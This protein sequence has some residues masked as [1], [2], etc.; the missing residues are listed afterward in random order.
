MPDV[1]RIGTSSEECH[2]PDDRIRDPRPRP[3]V[4]YDDDCGRADG[5]ERVAERVSDRR[6]VQW[7]HD[8]AAGYRECEKRSTPPA[9][10]T[11]DCRP[12]EL[13]GGQEKTAGQRVGPEVRAGLDRMA[14]DPVEC[15]MN[16]QAQTGRHDHGEA[17]DLVPR[18][19]TMPDKPGNG[20]AGHEVEMFLDGERPESREWRRE[21][22]LHVERHLPQKTRGRLRAGRQLH[23]QI[24]VE[25]RPQP[26]DAAHHE[27]RVIKAVG[28]GQLTQDQP[29]H[30]EP[31][32]HEEQVDARPAHHP[33][34]GKEQVER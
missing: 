19:T 10:Q 12:V 14:V 8:A 16:S 27:P 3:G 31:A 26:Q 2:G 29:P 30:Q 4:G 28:L 22:V 21:I 25:H 32:E 33:A 23:A 5:G 15:R 17:G 6:P 20:Q 24:E 34:G 11:E 18:F 7:C 1:D 9:R 13:Q